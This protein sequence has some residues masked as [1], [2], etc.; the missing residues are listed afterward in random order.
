MNGFK[1]VVVI[2][3]LM[4][5][6]MPCCHADDHDLHVHD[7]GAKAEIC[8]SHTCSCHSCDE[9]TCSDKLEMTP[10]LTTPS[11]T[12]AAPLSVIELYILPEDKP[13][14]KKATLP[15]PGVLATLQTVQLLI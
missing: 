10:G 15:P 5:A 13:V 11:A 4:V 3:A 14:L 1:H 6:A 2:V 12:V 9:T 8:A 7:A